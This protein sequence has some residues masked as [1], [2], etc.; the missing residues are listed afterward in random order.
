VDYQRLLDLTEDI[1]ILRGGRGSGNWA[2]SGRKGK[3]GG[4]GRGGG[5]K[6]IGVKP[7]AGRKEIKRASRQTRV[8]DERRKQSGKGAP[9]KSTTLLRKEK[10]KLSNIGFDAQ[11]ILG[12]LAGGKGEV[13]GEAN[14]KELAE[15]N[16]LKKAGFATYDGKTLKLTKNGKDVGEA[17]LAVEKEARNIDEFAKKLIGSKRTPGSFAEVNIDGFREL[18]GHEKHLL[19]LTLPLPASAKRAKDTEK[20][21]LSPV[22]LRK[23]LG[24]IDTSLN[25]QKHLN[26]KKLKT[27]D[28]FGTKKSEATELKG[29]LD[30]TEKILILRGGG[31]SGNWAHDGRPGRK[32]GSGRGGG[33]KRLRLKKGTTSRRDVKSISRR[34]RKKRKQQKEKVKRSAGPVKVSEKQLAGAKA[35]VIKAKKTRDKDLKAAHK[36]NREI[37][38][39]RAAATKAQQTFFKSS[40]KSQA[41]FKK[42]NDASDKA[43]K[44]SDEIFTIL[45]SGQDIS[46]PKVSSKLD[47]LQGQSAALRKKADK[48]NVEFQ[49]ASKKLDID[50]A[51][52]TQAEKQHDAVLA[53]NKGV[54]RTKDVMATF[55]KET[56]AASRIMFQNNLN[57]GKR[58][59]AQ[60]KEPG[61][62]IAS[63]QK[64]IDLN[65]KRVDEAFIKYNEL[66]DKFGPDD[67]RAQ[68]ALNEAN[69]ISEKIDKQMR[70]RK[71]LENQRS[72][73]A[74]QLLKV[75]NPTVIRQAPGSQKD[76]V[77]PLIAE[78]RNRRKNGQSGFQE[79]VSDDVVPK[80]SLVKYQNTDTGRAF[81]RN[82]TI[83]EVHMDVFSGPDTVVHELGHTAENY[84]PRLLRRSI[85]F[86]DRRTAGEEYQ[87]LADL[88]GNQGYRK[89]EKAKPD[90][91]IHPYMG[92]DYGESAS[93]IFSMGIEEMFRDP[94]GFAEKDPEMFDF[95]YA[96]ARTP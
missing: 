86:R 36:A 18:L 49:A 45:N 82:S 27:G 13:T 43:Q 11:N 72:E 55:E 75:G 53:K 81:Q 57:E 6:R 79:L 80:G 17:V 93:E 76:K 83:S 4:S 84:N 28:F 92:K 56:E 33:F 44:K 74:R 77:N 91:F 19:A 31:T 68:K 20:G 90:K 60:I 7:G 26:P 34:V 8:K 89:E 87:P 52:S 47:K 5:F 69:G 9:S 24:R 42:R 25:E 95:I 35:S 71:Q 61:K 16:K 3:R 51:K 23:V 46:D 73:S 88:T 41:A 40:D 30:L 94:V 66:V 78:T 64:D 96:Q 54:K 50:R 65:N 22:Q 14:E 32:G 39:S 15:I 62:K 58:V 37:E 29:L 10:T 63:I 38:K 67:S 70:E 21:S 2:H 85:D 1:L 59:R 12:S 48:A